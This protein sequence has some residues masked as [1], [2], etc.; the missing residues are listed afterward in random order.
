MIVPAVLCA[1]VLGYAWVS[2]AKAATPTKP[3]NG[4]NMCAPIPTGVP[5]LIQ[6]W[7]EYYSLD[8]ARMLRIAQCESRLD[9]RAQSRGGHYGVYQFLP[10]TYA[11]NYQ[12][13]GAGPD[14]WDAGN[15]VRT[16]AYMF[17]IGQ[18]WQ[19]ECKG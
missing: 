7:S 11:A 2:F 12:A 14:Y 9:P 15:N 16:A 3:C 10:N 19:W 13:A 8:G 5:E 6:Y 17:S 18:A 4:V 1:L